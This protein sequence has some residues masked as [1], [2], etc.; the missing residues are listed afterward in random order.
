MLIKIEID[1]YTKKGDSFETDI[2]NYFSTQIAEDR[3]PLKKECC[4]IYQ[5][6]AYYSKDRES[7]IIFDV[8]IEIYF[9]GATEYSF[10]WLIECKNY[11]GS[12]PVN[13]VEEF[14]SKVRQVAPANGKAIMASRSAFQMGGLNFARNKKMG[15][16]RYFD[17][18][19]AKWELHRSPSATALSSRKSDFEGLQVGLTSHDFQNGAFDLYMQCSTGPTNSL[20]DFS[21]CLL[22]ELALTDLQF[23]AIRN[24]KGRPANIVP[25]LDENSIEKKSLKILRDVGYQ[26]GRVSLEDIC[27][28]EAAHNGLKI[29]VNAP[30]RVSSTQTSILGSISFSPLEIKVYEQL[31]SNPGR[32]RFTLAHE[33]AHYLL[34]HGKY[35]LN[36]SCDEED[37]SIK[38]DYIALAPDILRMEYQA[39]IF[40]SCLLMPRN[41]FVEDF[42][43]ITEW[44]NIPD[45]GFGKLFLDSQ[46]CNY[47]NYERVTHELMKRYG[48]SRLAV[49]IRLDSLGLLRDVRSPKRKV[50]TFL[51]VG[52]A[53]AFKFTGI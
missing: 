15:I 8:S 52:Q 17:A 26:G 34:S 25:Y 3:L 23:R 12:V 49:A 37:F 44:L 31:N 41:H 10:I 11:A 51:E 16:L 22:S 7:H 6:K 4:K 27:S 1:E 42:K 40:A 13:D 32:D 20:W 36:E 39:N 47:Q 28:R 14:Y 38:S 24:P 2:Y 48:V 33:L 21:N 30:S 50:Q 18:S 46:L 19:N 9:A 5:K 45:R 43:R 29:L 53:H 35:M